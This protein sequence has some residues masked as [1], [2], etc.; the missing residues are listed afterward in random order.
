MNLK[1][2]RHSALQPGVVVILLITLLAGAASAQPVARFQTQPPANAAPA[3]PLPAGLQITWYSAA[4]SDPGPGAGQ[5]ESGG[6]RSIAAEGYDV[7][8]IHG[9][10]PE[11]CL[12]TA[13]GYNWYA[14]ERALQPHS[15]NLIVGQGG[16]CDV[17]WLSPEAM[18]A[19]ATPGDPNLRVSQGPQ[20]VAGQ[21]LDVLTLT[22]E[23]PQHGGLRLSRVYDTASGILLAMTEGT[24]DRSWVGNATMPSSSS[25]R[26]F[27]N[28]REISLPWRPDEP[29]PANIQGITSLHY[30]GS[31]TTTSLIGPPDGGFRIDMDHRYTV[32]QR[33][34]AWLLLQN[35]VTITMPGTPPQTGSMPSLL[36]AGN[37]F[38]PPAVLTGLRSGQVLDEHPVLGMRTTVESDPS[39]HVAIVE[40]AP[41]IN[42]RSIYDRAT[43]LL[44]AVF[45]EQQVG[46]R[47]EVTELRL[48]D[49]R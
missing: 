13:T 10:T 34:E 3:A 27:A 1:P 26:E 44:L 31:R 4:A 5:Q 11:G 39:G 12:A 2:T 20:V 49:A 45:V 47:R 48:V 9:W 23:Q 6:N 40:T 38:I 14:S 8:T 19:E 25:V 22:Y 29:L 33:S 32:Q 37:M 46:S 7:L 35:Q 24:G 16:R 21:T 43:G 28:V 41:G 17:F 42:A 18:Q 36:A 30:Q 15:S